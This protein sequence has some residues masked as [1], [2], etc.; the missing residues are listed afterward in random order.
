MKYADMRYT[1]SLATSPIVA[2]YACSRIDGTNV[3]EI[4]AAPRVPSR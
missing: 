2:T 4:R 1:D 3:F